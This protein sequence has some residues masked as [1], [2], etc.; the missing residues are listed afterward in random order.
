MVFVVN[1]VTPIAAEKPEP[2][3]VLAGFPA[4]WR[5]TENPGHC[6][7]KL[8]SKARLLKTFVPRSQFR[9]YDHIGR[10]EALAMHPALAHLFVE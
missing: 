1:A 8:G 10:A 5:P 9:R 7:A 4:E 3:P 2:V 6:L